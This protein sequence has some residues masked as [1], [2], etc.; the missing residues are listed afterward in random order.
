MNLVSLLR[1][2]HSTQSV[3]SNPKFSILFASLCLPGP[4][5]INFYCYDI[6]NSCPN[7][8]AYGQMIYK[9]HQDR[10]NWEADHANPKIPLC[11]C[12]NTMYSRIYS[13]TPSRGV[14]KNGGVP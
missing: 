12:Y 5:K 13:G 9:Q 1:L 8:V 6:N 7:N 11:F 3:K 14:G 4:D 2:L 10:Y